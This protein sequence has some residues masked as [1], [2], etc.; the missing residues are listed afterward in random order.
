MLVT[1]SKSV[2]LIRRMKLGKG[3]NFQE[4]FFEEVNRMGSVVV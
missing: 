4:I 3:W 2:F 1:G